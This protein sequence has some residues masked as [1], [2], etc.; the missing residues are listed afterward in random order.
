ME[1]GLISKG[2]EEER[3]MEKLLTIS[4]A[5]YNVEKYIRN[6]IESL[7]IED[8]DAL[9]ILV[10]D[11]GGT[12]RTAEIVYEYQGKYPDSIRLVN[13]ENGGY[14]ST[15]NASIKMAS[16]KYFKQLDG[17]DWYETENLSKLV[18]V[19]RKTDVDLIYTPFCDFIEQESKK[20][21]RRVFQTDMTGYHL[22]SEAITEC[23]GRINMYSSCFKTSILKEH[24][25]RL[26]ENC[27]YTDTEYALYPIAY[28]NDIYICDF[29]IYNYRLGV[30]GQSVSLEGRRKHYKDHLKV[31]RR[32]VSFY[33]AF[34][35]DKKNVKNY[36][37][38]YIKDTCSDGLTEYAMLIE[39]TQ[40]TKR[41]IVG[42]DLF[43]KKHAADVYDLIGKKSK[44]MWIMR[45]SNYALYYILAKIKIREVQ[46]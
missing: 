18:E 21:I 26:L 20:T 44:R 4:I 14:G 24:K 17:D 12:D 27:F 46:R 19:L 42:H 31:D 38:D 35:E 37:A 36:I 41:E 1:Y 10:Q 40:E 39:P 43:I 3:F 11:D 45:K 25:I 33:S 16:G 15:I 9:E 13:K 23:S 32:L 28:I 22:F 34:P 29:P 6:T 8:M 30:E 5:A 7:I 2:N